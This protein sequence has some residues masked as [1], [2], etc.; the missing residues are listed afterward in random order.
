MAD[1]AFKVGKFNVAF[2]A[3]FIL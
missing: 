3:Y 2:E 1:E